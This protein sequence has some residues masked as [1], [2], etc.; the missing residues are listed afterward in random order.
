[1]SVDLA[2]PITHSIGDGAIAY[3]HTFIAAKHGNVHAVVG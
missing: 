3:G 1:M 2:N